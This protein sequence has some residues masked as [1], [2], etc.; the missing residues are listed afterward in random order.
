MPRFRSFRDARMALVKLPPYGVGRFGQTE[1]AACTPVAAGRNI[2]LCM[3]RVGRPG[4]RISG[5]GEACRF[6]RQAGSRDRESLYAIHL[7]VRGRAIGLD[8]VARGTLTGVEVHPR[9]VFKAAILNNAAAILIG[10]NHPSGDATPSRA[11]IE[12]TRRLSDSGKMLGIHVLD[13]VIVTDT[14]CVGMQDREPSLFL[15][16]ARRKRRRRR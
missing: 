7:D 16:G 10:H 8:E 1:P 6:L 15:G 12:I 11:D 14:D 13:H 3:Q 5:A 9:E 2:R 4:P